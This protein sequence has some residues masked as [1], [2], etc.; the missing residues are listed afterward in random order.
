MI[1][2]K[3]SKHG[4]LVVPGSSVAGQLRRYIL[5]TCS[6]CMVR[7]VGQEGAY[8]GRVTMILNPLTFLLLSLGVANELDEYDLP[9]SAVVK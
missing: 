9:S 8:K 1:K 4:G 7:K 6:M 3:A 2:T 5:D